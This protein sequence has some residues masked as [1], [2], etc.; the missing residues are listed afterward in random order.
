MDSDSDRGVEVPRPYT[1]QPPAPG[2][3]RL[4]PGQGFSFGLTLFARALDLF[5]Y[6]VLALERMEQAG[7]GRRVRDNR[8]FR[9]RFRVR[10]VEAVNVLTG[11]A[12]EVVCAGDSLVKVPDVPVTHGQVAAWAGNALA[13]G[14]GHPGADLT[15]EYV[16]PTRIRDRFAGKGPDS[17]VIRPLFRPL[18][19]RLLERLTAL[20][21]HFSDSPLRLDFGA[22]VRR[23]ETVRLVEDRTR[24]LDLESHSERQRHR[25]PSGGFVGVATYQADDWAPF[26]PWLAWGQFTHVGKDAV[27][28][29]GWYRIALGAS[30]P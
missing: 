2:P 6:V 11:K 7:L 9:G 23:A 13:H 16:T 27:K 26:L 19:Q 14:L 21:Q 15:V 30:R 20:T 18:F 25:Y 8:N 1:I 17:L 3:R 28:G 4:E 22:L 5:P 29:N 24:W 10:R 12:S